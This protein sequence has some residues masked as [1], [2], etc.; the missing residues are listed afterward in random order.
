MEVE[1]KDTEVSKP[2]GRAAIIAAYKTQY[3]E[4]QEPDDDTLHDF[5]NERYFNLEGI[6]NEVIGTNGQLANFVDLF[7]FSGTSLFKSKANL[8]IP[9]L[10]EG[11]FHVFGYRNDFM[12]LSKLT[13][14]LLV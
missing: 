2:K 14:K 12:E 1:N 11:T 10:R 8:A 9:N 13:K 6:H 3:P 5:S 7:L 4:A